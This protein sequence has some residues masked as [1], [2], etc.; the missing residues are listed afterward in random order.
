LAIRSARGRRPR[1]A[2]AASV[3]EHSPY[4]AF[5]IQRQAP[6]L[7]SDGGASAALRAIDVAVAQRTAQ[8]GPR[9][10]CIRPIVDALAMVAPLP[11]KP[12]APA[13][14]PPLHTALDELHAVLHAAPARARDADALWR[15]AVATGWLSSL[16]AKLTGGSPG[17]AGL[18][19]LLHRS[20]EALALQALAASDD[21][22]LQGLDRASM[23]QCCVDHESALVAALG[24]AWRLPP[25]VL[26]AISG[27]RRAPEVATATSEARAVYYAH[28][29]ASQVLLAEFPAPGLAEQ[30]RAELRLDRREMQRVESAIAGLRGVIGGLPGGRG[31]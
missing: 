5:A 17:T 21:P 1:A 9:P 28:A 24:R 31:A 13:S 23:R 4:M 15:E 22:L 10:S 29:F 6:G 18:A 12:T 30:A 20:G 16:L 8:I 14:C 11:P 27:W 2:T 19:G 26:A 3:A 25:G 7:Q